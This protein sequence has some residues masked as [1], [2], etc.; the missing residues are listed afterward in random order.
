MRVSERKG[1]TTSA[2]PRQ[3]EQGTSA[4][5]RANLVV[6]SG[7][8]ESGEYR[9]PSTP[10]LLYWPVMTSPRLYRDGDTLPRHLGKRWSSAR[11]KKAP[12]NPLS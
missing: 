9:A 4:A 12:P 5:C 6:G 11:N 7:P 10:L 1:W 8:H 2:Y 3:G